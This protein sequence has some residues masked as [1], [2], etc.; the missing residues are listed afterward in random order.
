MEDI[1]NPKD[2]IDKYCGSILVFEDIDLLIGGER[3]ANF[4]AS[5]AL[6]NML[7]ILDN[8]NKV[9]LTT[10]KPS[11]LDAALT[12]AGRIDKEYKIEYLNKTEVKR[13]ILHIFYK[14]VSILYNNSSTS[15]NMNTFKDVANYENKLVW[16]EDEIFSRCR[17]KKGKYAPCE[18]VKAFNDYI[19]DNKKAYL[20]SSKTNVI[21]ND[22]VNTNRFVKTLNKT[23]GKK[24][25]IDTNI[26]WAVGTLKNIVGNIDSTLRESE[27]KNKKEEEAEERTI[28]KRRIKYNKQ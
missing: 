20:C 3:N 11:K 16:L 7:L 12:R 10:N 17:P 1:L 4:D 19:T 28:R 25:L 2:V 24:G 27:S 15:W 23:A 9:I 5:R 26:T 18:V 22:S 14:K 13:L 6:Q 8:V 21:S